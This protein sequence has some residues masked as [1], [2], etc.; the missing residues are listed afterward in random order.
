MC[1]LSGLMVTVI[2]DRERVTIPNGIVD[3]K[4]FRRW[5]ETDDFPEIGHIYWL[6]GEV[7]VD[8]SREQVYTHSDVK[9]EI[10][11]VLRALDKD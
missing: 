4:S 1:G 5:V 9:S 6:N 7:C 11:S 10:G 2:L 8:L 3:L